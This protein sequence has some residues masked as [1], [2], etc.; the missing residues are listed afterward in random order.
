MLHGVVEASETAMI[1]REFGVHVAASSR[2]RWPGLLRTVLNVRW[3]TEPG[4]IALTFD[5]PVLCVA[6]SETGGRC[7]IRTQPEQPAQGDYF[8]TGHLSFV[9][10]SQPLTIYATEM[11]DSRI[12]L[13]QL[14]LCKSDC[15][16]SDQAAVIAE[17]ESRYMFRNDRLYECARLLGEHEVTSDPDIYGLSLARALQLALFGAPLGRTKSRSSV[18]LTGERFAAVLAHINDHLDQSTAVKDLAQISNM[19]PAQFGRSFQEAT[20]MSL[21]RWQMDARIRSAQRLMMDDPAE[22]LTAIAALVGFSDS[23]HFSRA[24]LEIVGTT[25]S[26]WLRQRT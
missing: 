20:G 4:W 2:Q 25:P 7:Q 3:E 26:A 17:A 16:N 22:S 10:A 21:Q 19:S 24:F 8:G 14:D 15:L 12:A 6:L 11:R 13:Y 23:S 1:T 18:K 9:A 5:S